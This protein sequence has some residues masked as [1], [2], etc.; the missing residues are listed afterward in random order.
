[1]SELQKQLEVLLADLD[2]EVAKQVRLQVAFMCVLPE[3]EFL[4]FAND[5]GRF[6]GPD[7]QKVVMEMGEYGNNR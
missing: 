6:Y 3:A 4:E 5:I 2:K 7:L 1:M